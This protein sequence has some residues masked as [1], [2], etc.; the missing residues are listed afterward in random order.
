MR[1]HKVDS[2]AHNRF[3]H[4]EE[5][6]ETTRKNGGFIFESKSLVFIEYPKTN[7]ENL[8]GEKLFHGSFDRLSK[9]KGGIKHGESIIFNLKKEKNT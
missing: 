2:D 1:G 5:K 7:I 9:N 3:W 6:Q 4:Q 8:T